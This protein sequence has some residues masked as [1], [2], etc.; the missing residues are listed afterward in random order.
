MEQ[1]IPGKGAAIGSLVCGIASLVIMWFGWGAIV[2]VICSI[3][4]LVLASNSK[5]AGFNGGIRTGG[6]VCSL[7]GLILGAI[8]LVCWIACVACANAALAAL[9]Y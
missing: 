2:A 9:S 3:V 4:G 1:N 6:F 5:K 8:V 7:I